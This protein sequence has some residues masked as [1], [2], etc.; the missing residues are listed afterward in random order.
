MPDLRIP[1]PG[2][3]AGPLVVSTGEVARSVGRVARATAAPLLPT[4]SLE[5]AVGGRT[6][7]VTGSSY[8]IG[9]ATAAQ[10]AQAGATT[11]LVARDEDRLAELAS[12]IAAG[13]GAAHAYPADLADMEAIARLA[14]RLAADGHEVDVLVNNAAR[15]IR[16]SLADTYD[17]LH[18]FERTM[19]LNYFGAVHLTMALLPGMRE[20]GRGHVV[21]VSTMG[22]QTSTPRFAAYLASKAALEAF[23]RVAAAE[24]LGDGVRFSV[25]HMPLVRTP[26]IEPTAAYEGLPALS[27]EQAGGL[28]GEALRSQA[29]YV[30]PRVGTASEVLSA[31]F[32]AGANEVLHAL[33][34]GMQE[35]E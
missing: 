27:P 35:P 4:R 8:G 32:P 2:F 17:R 13:G 24:C 14:D 7:L 29:E 16:R 5:A 31:L 30:G 22:T 21:N 19:R 3:P 11:I 34:R 26:M 18:D 6:V 15:S 28:I 12:E 10:V 25:V 23:T 20:R 9:R 33:Y 1:L